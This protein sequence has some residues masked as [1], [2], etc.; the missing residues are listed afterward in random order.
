[1][2]VPKGK[3]ILKDL[4]PKNHFIPIKKCNLKIN[5]V[6]RGNPVTQAKAHVV[7]SE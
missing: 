6:S 4:D 3:T 7:Q 5:L 1:M 2:E